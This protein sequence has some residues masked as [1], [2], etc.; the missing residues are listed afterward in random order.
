MQHTVL[1]TGYHLLCRADAARGISAMPPADYAERF[2]AFVLHEVLH[3]P[4]ML[5]DYHP[6]V[7]PP[8]Y[9]PI[10]LHEVL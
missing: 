10:L 9:H 2:E 8:D 6:A 1:T 3:R 7:M 4:L 5:P